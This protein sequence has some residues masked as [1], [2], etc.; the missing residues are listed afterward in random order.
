MIWMRL[1]TVALATLVAGSFAVAAQDAPPE[2][3][4]KTEAQPEPEA[5]ID[6]NSAPEGKLTVV[7]SADIKLTDKAREKELTLIAVYPEESGKYP[8]VFFSHG[9]DRQADD[10]ENLAEYWAGHGYVVL[11]PTHS[12]VRLGRVEQM[13]ADYDKDKDGKLSKEEVPEQIQSFF[14]TLDTDGDG[15]LSKEELDV[16]GRMG[17]RGGNRGGG[18][19]GETPPDNPEPPKDGEDEFDMVGDP[20]EML[21]G[22]PAQPEPP[23]PQPRQRQRR[24]RRSRPQPALAA[25]TGI[26]RVGDIS[27]VLSNTEAL[28]KAVPALKDKLNLEKVAVSGHNAGAYT[29]QIIGGASIDVEETVTAEDGTESTKTETRNLLD[30]RVKAILALS[31]AGPDQGGLTKES[32]K[33]IKVPAMNITGSEDT[34]GEGQDAAWKKQAFELSGEGDKYQVFVEGASN[35]SFTRQRRSFRRGGEDQPT[36]HTFDWVKTS[37]LQFLNAT[38]KGDEKAKTWLTGGALKEATEGA[39]IIE[40]K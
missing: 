36:D 5:T 11:M 33:G 1:M 30:K 29:S 20:A 39:A 13:L 17:G 12:D 26:D 38:L 15:F 35:Y 4:K 10:G 3:D 6:P 31:P 7:T 9:A 2:P 25:N 34:T 8:V 19:G 22:D 16:V 24:G 21:L 27:F 37:T 14:E 23:Q 18:R 28:M 32:F 40:S